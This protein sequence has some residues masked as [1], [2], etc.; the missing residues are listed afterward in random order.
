[1]TRRSERGRAIWLLFLAAPLV[2]FAH[3]SLLYG[4]ASFGSAR[5]FTIVAWA[6]TGVACILVAGVWHLGRRSRGDVRDM[7]RW[8]ALLSLTGILFQGLS[9]GLLRPGS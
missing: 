5:H 4:L 7:T 8:I 3:F 2:W 6:A 9:L 1:M